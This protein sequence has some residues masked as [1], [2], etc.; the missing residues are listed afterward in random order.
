M[1]LTERVYGDA[2]GDRAIDP[3]AQAEDSGVEAALVEVIARAKRESVE[4][5][6]RF[7]LKVRRLWPR[8]RL[9]FHDCTF[10]GEGREPGVQRPAGIEGQR[11]AV[12]D[13]L[14]VATDRVA[15]MDRQPM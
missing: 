5:F 4:E 9:Q 15:V 1:L 2:S 12:K 7:G 13:Q 10:L 8:L 11:V 3:A 14:V 6:L